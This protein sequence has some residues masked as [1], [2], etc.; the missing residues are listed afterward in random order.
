M[1]SLALVMSLVTLVSSNMALADEVAANSDET[2]SV[3]ENDFAAFDCG[4]S[5]C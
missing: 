4:G 5:C 3:Q 2:A 1:R